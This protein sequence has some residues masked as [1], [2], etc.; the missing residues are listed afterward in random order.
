MNLRRVLGSEEFG[1]DTNSHAHR[2][3]GPAPLVPRMRGTSPPFLKTRQHRS[4][5]IFEKSFLSSLSFSWR[6]ARRS[7]KLPA[8]PALKRRYSLYS[9]FGNGQGLDM[10]KKDRQKERGALY[11]RCDFLPDFTRSDLVDLAESTKSDGRVPCASSDGVLFAFP[12]LSPPP[13]QPRAS[14]Y[15]A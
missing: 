4:K 6:N 10:V 8:G 15:R 5:S 9:F 14:N 2:G 11:C 13:I 3:W 12:P 7:F 1:L